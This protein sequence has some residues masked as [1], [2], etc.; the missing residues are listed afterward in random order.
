MRALRI[1]VAL[2][3]GIV[4]QTTL[5][6]AIAIFGVRP[7]FPLLIAIL[8]ALRAGP[9]AGALTGF[10][11][12]LFVDLNSTHMLGA[13]SLANGVLGWALGSWSDRLVRDSVVARAGVAF[14][15]TVVR[16]V[17]LA[18]FLVPSGIGGVARQL[19]LGALPGGLYTAALAIPFMAFAER[20]IGWGRESGRG[21]S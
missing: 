12:G 18:L 6:P 3:I 15:A 4:L 16:D 2:W 8:V 1:L 9:A 7:D 19:L 11:A 20:V 13:S 17:A 10:A 5:A 14:V 21:V